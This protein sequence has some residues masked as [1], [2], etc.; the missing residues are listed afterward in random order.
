MRA[1]AALSA[2]LETIEPEPERSQIQKWRDEYKA[3]LKEEHAVDS[4]NAAT[5]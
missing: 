2:V 3:M 1:E 5:E 4:E